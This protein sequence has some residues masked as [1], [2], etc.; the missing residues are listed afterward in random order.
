MHK[1]TLYFRGIKKGDKIQ[2]H[3]ARGSVCLGASPAASSISLF[4]LFV[5]YWYLHC[6]FIIAECFIL[7]VL[8]YCQVL[9]VSYL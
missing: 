2:S 7:D 9:G 8:V 1:A 6:F 3:P 4:T 5:L